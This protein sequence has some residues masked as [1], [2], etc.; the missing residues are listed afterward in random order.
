MNEEELLEQLKHGPPPDRTPP[1]VTAECVLAAAVVALHGVPPL[2]CTAHHK[3]AYETVYTQLAQ[4]PAAETVR[5]RGTRSLTLTRTLF[6]NPN[7]NHHTKLPMRLQGSAGR[8]QGGV[9]AEGGQRQQDQIVRA[10]Q[11]PAAREA[12]DRREAHP[13]RSGL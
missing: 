10:A 4:G 12:A 7:P 11:A 13:V 3:D 5:Q 2:Q 8:R 9:Q 1:A 6:L